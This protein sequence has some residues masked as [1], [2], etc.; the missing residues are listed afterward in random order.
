MA[1]VAGGRAMVAV[2]GESAGWWPGG[3]VLRH[4]LAARPHADTPTRRHA[5]TPLTPCHAQARLAL[6]LH[7]RAGRARP[8]R[9]GRLANTL[10]RGLSPLVFTRGLPR[11]RSTELCKPPSV[12]STPSPLCP[13][14][15]TTPHPPLLPQPHPARPDP[16]PQMGRLAQTRPSFRWR[17]RARSMLAAHASGAG[18]AGA[19]RV[20]DGALVVRCATADTLVSQLQALLRRGAGPPDLLVVVAATVP[21]TP[22]PAYAA[23]LELG[24]LLVQLADPAG[25]GRWV[26]VVSHP[27]SPGS[28]ERAGPGGLG[29]RA[30]NLGPFWSVLPAVRLRL[31]VVRA[32]PATLAHPPQT[33]ADMNQVCR[34][35]V[36]R[37]AVLVRW[38]ASCSGA[39]LGPR[40]SALCRHGGRCPRRPGPGASLSTK[41]RWGAHV[42]PLWG[43][44]HWSKGPSSRPGRGACCW[45]GRGDRQGPGAGRGFRPGPGAAPAPG[46]GWTAQ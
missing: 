3:F 40:A 23:R 43:R 1:L 33:H 15:L 44:P 19:V 34:P 42:E 2:A 30:A 11:R 5:H 41:Q 9:P 6:V 10:S 25:P 12:L 38:P 35:A 31:E 16:T 29:S 26:L 28:L 22:P 36:A 13:R 45:T 27:L 46:C 37:Q 7:C 39:G 4:A 8:S 24:D 14:H 18:A 20:L 17:P 21:L 32:P